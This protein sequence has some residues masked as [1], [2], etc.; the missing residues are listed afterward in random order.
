MSPHNEKAREAEVRVTQLGEDALL[1]LFTSVAANSVNEAVQQK[2]WQLTAWLELQRKSL[3]LIEVVP[4]M[5][6]L[7]LQAGN[8]SLLNTLKDLV[9]SHWQGLDQ[10]DVE[11]RC[12]EIPV[13]YG[14]DFGPD[15]DAVAT[16]CGLSPSEVID[17]HCQAEYRVY[18]LG[19][20][21]GFA[22]LA[23]LDPALHIPR[24]DTPRLS[25]PAGSVAIAGA[26]T[27]VYPLASPGGWHLIGRTDTPL[28]KPSA[29][30][31]AL[32]RPGDRVR[33]VRYGETS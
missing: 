4:G 29:L 27:A 12:I 3:D 1:F 24:R 15:L 33:F 31:A 7:L 21:P 17:R 19:F 8:S 23:G 30:H 32:L 13:H 20:Q 25:V 9:L 10:G 22:Y 16:H 18:C 26:Q 5:G 6:N 11:G 2:L 28:F 14:E